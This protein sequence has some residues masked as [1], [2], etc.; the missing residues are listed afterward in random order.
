MLVLISGTQVSSGDPGEPSH[1]VMHD[2][3]LVTFVP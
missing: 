1:G 3:P 2:D